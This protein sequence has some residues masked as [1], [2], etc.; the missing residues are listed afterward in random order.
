MGT[1]FQPRA[2][3]GANWTSAN[4]VLLANELAL[5][6]TAKQFKVGDGTSAWTALPYLMLNT[7]LANTWTAEQTF[8]ATIAQTPGQGANNETPFLQASDLVSDYVV[9]G[10]LTPVPSSASLTGTLAAGT[11]YVLGQRTVLQAAVAYTY[12]AS[13][14]TYV[15]LSYS[16][17][18][19]YSAVANGAT[20]PAVAADSLR[21]EKV[22]TSS[23]AITSVTQ[24]A[25]TSPLLS[26]TIVDALGYTPANPGNTAG[27]TWAGNQIIPAIA[28]QG[29]NGG[30]N[31][32]IS[33]S[34][35]VT[36]S[37]TGGSIAASTTT[38]YLV[39]PVY[40]AGPS[41]A[42]KGLASE[43]IG[44]SVTTGSSTSTNSNA[45]TWG[46][47]SG[48]VSYNVYSCSSGELQDYALIG[49]TTSTSFTD[50]G[51]TG[52]G[53][54]PGIVNSYFQNLPLSNVVA[55]IAN[56]WNP[57]SQTYKIPVT[58]WYSVVTNLRVADGTTGGLSCS[59]NAHNQIVDAPSNH[60]F[61]TAQV[62]S[63]QTARNG[64]INAKLSYYTAGTEL[65]IVAGAGAPVNS[66]ALFLSV[67]FLGS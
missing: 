30:S 36:T 20:A 47:Q 19:T 40:E 41:V 5:D 10:L 21:L 14:D 16:G 67:A 28:F 59:I 66:M 55:D 39:A 52:S 48:A 18:L 31:G 53:L 27:Y 25:N 63:G 32:G 29:Y 50:T 42:P 43:V 12:A 26:S 34:P 38:Y 9:S 6:T 44:T 64:G 2:D 15:D 45:L 7:G 3:T 35:T 33:I 51:I 17:V 58:G 60:W 23:T 46:A 57:A 56:G 8:D 24:L 37:T 22:V 13:S 65:Y 54:Y 1:K 11:A 49:N 62:A 61:V 4:P